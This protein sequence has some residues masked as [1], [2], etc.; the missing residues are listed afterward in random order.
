MGDAALVRGP[1][2]IRERDRQREQPVERKSI[3][4]NQIRKR[5]AVDQLE[6]EERNTVDL[7][8][9]VDGDD[10]RVVE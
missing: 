4:R 5:L 9:R 2:R 3:V 8:D 6:G 10:V 1:N 7:L